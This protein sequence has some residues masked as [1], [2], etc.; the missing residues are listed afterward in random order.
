MIR[1]EIKSKHEKEFVNA[2][3]E[4]DV[5][6]TS[7]RVVDPIIEEENGKKSYTTFKIITETTFPQFPGVRFEVRRRYNDFVWLRNYLDNYLTSREWKRPVEPLPDLPGDSFSSFFGFGR[8]EPGFIED[9][10]AKL[11]LFINK[12]ASHPNCN[13]EKGLI[14]FL[15]ESNIQGSSAGL[16][17]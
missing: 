6:T 1:N 7:V 10:R 17:M 2:Y 5:W 11:E 8:F 15:T 16:S 13:H 12:I 14:H 4:P 3:E 9:R